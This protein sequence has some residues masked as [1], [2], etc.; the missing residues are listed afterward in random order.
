MSNP[1]EFDY[2]QW[3]RRYWSPF[4]RKLFGTRDWKP[5]KETPLPHHR[6]TAQDMVIP[7]DYK[8]DTPIPEI[9]EG[10]AGNIGLP[11]PYPGY[12]PWA[13]HLPGTPYQVGNSHLC[14]W[15]QLRH[16]NAEYGDNKMIQF[17]MPKDHGGNWHREGAP[18]P[19]FVAAQGGWADNHI[20]VY[21]EHTGWF[22]EAIGYNI[23]F[24]SVA[25]YGI[26]DNEGSLVEGRGVIWSKDPIGPYIFDMTTD[27]PH[28]LLL[29]VSNAAGG[30]NDPPQFPWVGRRLTLSEE[31]RAKV[32]V[33][34]SGTPEWAFA[35]SV[36]E[37]EIVVSDHGGGCGFRWVCGDQELLQQLDWQGWQ[38]HMSDLVPCDDKT[39]F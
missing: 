14:G 28:Q 3:T 38:P 11:A 37:Y 1:Y 21:D 16:F 30:D 6:W 23:L 8:V 29:V 39:G 31:G 19:S 32:P 4:W 35:R 5:V 27:T 34:E 22:Y 2:N 15:R 7:Y 24:E 13:V 33:Y 10:P 17:P 20:C 9:L 25:A 12:G 36:M 18:L 26:F